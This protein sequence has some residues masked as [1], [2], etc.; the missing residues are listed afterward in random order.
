MKWHESKIQAEQ[1]WNKN[2]PTAPFYPDTDNRRYMGFRYRDTV[3]YDLHEFTES[4][5]VLGYGQGNG[6]SYFRLKD[7]DD[8]IY[9]ISLNDFYKVMENSEIK[10][11]VIEPITW[12]FKKVGQSYLIAPLDF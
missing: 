8:F 1:K 12:T 7:S 6:S 5:T 2:L 4:L 3:W 10:K 9:R 11:N